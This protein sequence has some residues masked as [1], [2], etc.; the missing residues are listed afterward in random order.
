MARPGSQGTKAPIVAVSCALSLAGMALR[1]GP[2]AVAVAS[3]D[4]PIQ[5][6]DATTRA[7]IDY[8]NLFGGPGKPYIIESTGN[9]AAW[10][11]CEI[12]RASCRERV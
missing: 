1:P 12:G 6:E 11:D 4:G 9:G 8:R 3:A 5:F 7:G 2:P 10:L